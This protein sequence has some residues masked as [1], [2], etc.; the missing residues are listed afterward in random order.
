MANPFRAFAIFQFA[1]Q[2]DSLPGC[3]ILLL[4]LELGSKIEQANLLFLFGN[5]FVQKGQ[6]I[7][8]EEN[9]RRIVDLRILADVVLKEDGRHGCDVFVAEPQIGAGKA[10]I[11]GLNG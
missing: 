11:T 8:E 1:V 6:V 9:G 7:A 2:S 10:S 4:E 5:N 3:E